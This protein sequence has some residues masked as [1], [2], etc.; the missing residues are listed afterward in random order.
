MVVRAAFAVFAAV[1]VLFAPSLSTPAAAQTVTGTMQ[2]TA[3]DTSG[4]VLPGVTITIASVETGGTREVVTNDA[5]FFHTPFLPLGQYRVT[6]TLSNFGTVVREGIEITLNRTTVVDFALNPSVTDTVTVRAAA[7]VI[8]STN[9]EIKSSLTAAQ[10]MDK[11]TLNPGSFLSLAEIFPGFQENPFS[12]Q[13]NPTLSS[14]S[15]INFNGT[16][17]RAATFQIN[18]VNNDDSSENQ[19]RQG[20]S[21]STI[22]E[23]QV[24]S[25]SYTAE[26]GRSAGAVVLVQTKSGTNTVHGD[27]YEY[28]QNNQLNAKAFFSS[29]LPKA[30]RTRH[31]FGG[32]VGFPLRRDKLF[33]FLSADRTTV[34][35]ESP[36]TRDLFLPAEL[37]A[38]RLTRGNDNPANRA[39]IE[40]VLARY[41]SG[42]TPNDSRSP[43]TYQTLFSI[44]QPDQDYSG[45]IDWNAGKSDTLFV[46]QQYTRQIRTSQDII[47]GEQARQNNKQQNIGA[48]WTHIFSP[49]TL[50]EFR[51]G[52]GTRDTNV[53]IAAG[54]DTPIIRFA[55]SPVSGAIIGNAG[56]Y[57]INRHQNDHQFV[58]NLSTVLGSN[59]SIKT[60]MDIRRQQLDD[61]ADNFTRGFWS[62][63]RVCLGT[64][65]D[66]AYAAF[67]D[68][69]VQNFQRG[70]GPAFLENRLNEYNLYAEDSWR[71]GSSLTLNLG[72]RYEYVSA[73]TEAEDR[74][75]YGMS[76]D[77]NN[78]EPRLGFAYAPRWS[79]GFLGR[80]T[81]GPENASIRGGYGM[82]HGRIYQSV[83]SQGGA[84][85]RFNPPNAAFINIT[86]T[87]TQLDLADPTGGFVFQP[88]QATQTA[89]LMITTVDP[90]LEMP[91]THQWNLTVERRMP[92]NSSVRLT[93]SGTRGMGFLKYAQDNLP[94]SPLDRPFTV[95]DHPLNAPAAGFPDL[96]GVTIDRVATDVNCAGTGL[97]GLPVNAD[98]PNVVPIANNEVSFRVPRVN[99]RRPD[100]RYTTNLKISNGADQWYNGLQVE[101]IKRL[102]ASLQFQAAYTWGKALDTLSEATSG[103][104]GDTNQTGLDPRFSRGLALFDTRHRFTFNGSYRLPFF[105]ERRDLAGQLLGGWQASAV[106]KLVSGSPFTVTNG[107]GRDLNFDGFSE[108][109]RPV[110][111]D[112][113]LLYTSV[114]DPSTS[115]QD[116]PL[117]AFRVPQFGDTELVGRNTFF[118]D[119]TNTVDLGL[120][121]SFALPADHRVLLR[122]EMYN[123]FNQ[124]QFGFPARSI[125]TPATF[126]Q[127]TGTSTLYSPRVI[128]IAVR[129]LF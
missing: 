95:I 17:S 100:P 82:Y 75:D 56:A 76:D 39:F 28:Y 8:N 111:T 108:A 65:Y 85:I 112:P 48:T 121:K 89:R 10:I 66:T 67:L 60:G 40:S 41:P 33:A 127:I 68:G 29:Q 61:R 20:V 94:I 6:A 103:A 119:G 30:D 115:R 18:G 15:S 78:V 125:D 32:T 2:G 128:Q 64:T 36:Y 21:L 105:E 3:R 31:Q 63:N 98:C 126:G 7:P 9:G 118:G 107:V 35:G 69:C 26:F 23:F 54:N 11:P 73:P 12:G 110:L 62:F 96:R 70:Y 5:G 122:L 53:D 101:W 106:V 102:S 124:A 93:Y 80:L 27:L 13:N 123:A 50:G 22:Q 71:L 45:R 116:L 1:L 43:R 86:N 109:A 55:A 37:A 19:N 58:Y 72:V 14:G 77:R 113:S 34:E 49:R 51:Y 47:I 81:G 120:Y 59:H 83:F 114:D 44:D 84:N 90:A 16:G 79:E 42:A 104:G 52:L 129:Y 97:P 57:P 4:A 87:S 74:F 38:P 88:G 25:N 117:S 99:E 24:I 46:R 91:Y 92:F